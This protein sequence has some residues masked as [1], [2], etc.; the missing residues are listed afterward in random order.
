MSM[1]KNAVTYILRKRVKSLI[2]FCVLLCMSTM[3]LSSIAVKKA[4]DDAA[5][6]TF[7]SINSSFS[8]QINR[9]VNQGTPRGSG[10]I[11]GKDIDE[12]A[13]TKGISGYVKRMGV[14]GDL[15]NHSLVEVPE[16]NGAQISQERR[17]KF[18]KATMITGVN[19]SSKDDR[20]VAETFKLKEGKHIADSDK[21][22]ALVH[23]DFAKKNNL[24]IGDKFKIKS[25]T[26]DP[27][28][29]K[30]ANETVEVKIVGLFS[31]KNK[32][33]VGYPQ[34]LYENLILTDLSTSR[35]L[36]GYDQNTEIYQDGTF[37]VKGNEDIEKVMKDVQKLPIDWQKYTLLKSSN[38]FPVLQQSINA[39][40]GMAD[41]LFIGS[42]I[43]SGLVLTLILFLWVNGRRKEI[44]ILLSIGTS[45][46][47]I[48]G[49][50]VSEILFV[51]IFSFIGSFYLGKATGQF[52]GKTIL[53]Q[54][55]NSIGKGIASEAQGANLGGG[56]DVDGFNKMITDLKVSVM[57]GDMKWVVVFGIA[58]IVI[59]VS[60]ASFKLIKKHPKELL[61]DI[62]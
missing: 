35:T 46:A 61:A 14:I 4:T 15:V 34:E 7:K 49:Q 8:I 52:I 59:A 53:S 17:E 43:F 10:N 38:N 29:E 57:A 56:A 6:E 48:M 26:Y 32:G 27:D 58:V 23:E 28:N 31:G 22:T 51:S 24:K 13:K 12:I 20:F 33:A 18:G 30:K 60:V 21:S 16:G 62:D 47:K 3:T 45:K 50:F 54:V 42:L 44:G 1:L 19:D 55:S 5:K 39:I 41:K 25:N 40:Y 11:K 2:I 36:Y 9:R 37:M